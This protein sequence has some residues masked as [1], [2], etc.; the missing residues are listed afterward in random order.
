MFIAPILY[1]AQKQDVLTQ[2]YVSNE[3]TKFVDS[4][5]N[6]GFISASMYQEFVRKIDNT[7]NLYNITIEHAHLRVEPNVDIETNI[8]MDDYDSYYYNT[9]EEA[10][11][12]AFDR[13][14]D[15]YFNQGDYISV[16]VVNRNKTLAVRIME[17]FY[18]WDIPDQQILVT[19]GGMIRDDEVN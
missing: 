14:E 1:M 3:T 8:V 6:T 10:I 5:K 13:G 17:A 15:Y 16:K 19:Y 11:F 7:G 18:K 12:E 4:I 9:Y 2:N